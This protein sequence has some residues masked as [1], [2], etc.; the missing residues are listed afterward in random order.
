MDQCFAALRLRL[1]GLLTSRIMPA[2]E[3][4]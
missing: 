3:T 4:T 2:T 1:E